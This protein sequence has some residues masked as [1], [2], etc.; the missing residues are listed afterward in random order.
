MPDGALFVCA[1]PLG[2]LSDVSE[3]LRETLN[4][5][6]VV[7]AEDTRRT[8]KLMAHVGANC[9]VRS[10]FSG[11]EQSR[12]AELIDDLRSGQSVALVSDAGM[13]GVSDPGAVSVDL[14]LDAGISVTVIPG[15]SAVT[16]AVALAG[17]G[18]DRFVFEGFL[19]R[20]GEDRLLRIRG[21]ANDSRPAV[22]FATPHRVGADLV[23]LAENL[24]MERRITVA[25]EMTK[26]H[27]EVWRGAL[28][29]A[30]ERWA[31]EQKGEFTLVIEGAAGGPMTLDAAIEL[32]QKHLAGGMAPSEAA[33]IAAHESGVSK[34]LIYQGILDSQ[35]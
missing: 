11:N 7:Y 8:A 17:F 14:A 15:P 34:R 32:A 25:R 22:V 24:G 35:V 31:G 10:L 21:L 12:T 20:K 29:E 27:E 9:R 3:R 33:G 5:V 30:V 4:S 16:S 2:N 26:L 19:P 13:P 28:G 6:D 18:G 1:T 23:D